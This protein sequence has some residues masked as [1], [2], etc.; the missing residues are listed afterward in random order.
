MGEVILWLVVFIVLAITELA[1]LQLVSIWFSAAG[2]VSMI[3]AACGVPFWV[4]ILVF[5]VVAGILLLVTRPF[6]AKHLIK[7]SVPT[8]SELDVGKEALVIEDIDNKKLKGRVTLNGVD[9]TARTTDESNIIKGETVIVD[10]I[11]G[12]KLLVKAKK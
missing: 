3:L 2:F 11:D 9:W 10:S 5:I 7:K 12:S 6:V 8:N 1:T 4:Q